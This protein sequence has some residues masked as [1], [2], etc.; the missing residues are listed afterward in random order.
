MKQPVFEVWFIYALR[1]YAPSHDDDIRYS[2]EA[3]KTPKSRGG[4]NGFHGTRTSADKR[5]SAS[6]IRRARGKHPLLTETVREP[7][8]I[9]ATTGRTL[10]RLLNDDPIF[11][12]CL[13]LAPGNQMLRVGFG[14]VIADVP[15]AYEFGPS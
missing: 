5:A 7:P 13:E 2:S 3:H 10:Q 12:L 6:R 4:R 9:A 11:R 15:V 8:V 1:S 14:R